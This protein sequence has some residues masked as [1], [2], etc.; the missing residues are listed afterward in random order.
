MGIGSM[1]LVE[2][3]EKIRDINKEMAIYATV[4]WREDS[5]SI[6]AFE[7]DDGG[8]PAEAAEAECIYFLEVSIAC[9]FIEAWATSQS[10]TPTSLEKCARLNETT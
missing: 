3:I 4:P 8:L 9:E 2:L 7:P 5:L 6:V 1:N 10:R